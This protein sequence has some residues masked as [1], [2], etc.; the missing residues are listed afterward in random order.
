MT[1]L[2]SQGHLKDRIFVRF[3]FHFMRK[4]SKKE[5]NMIIVTDYWWMQQE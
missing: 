2:K 3:L 1:I 5:K 4:I